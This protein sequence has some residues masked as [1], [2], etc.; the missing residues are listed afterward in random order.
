VPAAAKYKSTGGADHRTGKIRLELCGYSKGIIGTIKDHGLKEHIAGYIHINKF[1]SQLVNFGPDHP[2]PTFDNPAGTGAV[3]VQL[4]ITD[5]TLLK[6]AS[7]P[8]AYATDTQVRHLL[9][10]LSLIL[11]G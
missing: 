5:I 3:I 6:R 1:K 7:A 9:K 11:D 10:A 8:D 4:K 2:G